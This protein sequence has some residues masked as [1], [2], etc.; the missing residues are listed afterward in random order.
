MTWNWQQNTLWINY[1][2]LWRD[3]HFYLSLDPK[4]TVRFLSEHDAEK[5]QLVD[6]MCWIRAK[7]KQYNGRL[8]A[9]TFSV[10]AIRSDALEHYPNIA[11]DGTKRLSDENVLPLKQLKT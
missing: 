11:P 4:E 7:R 5:P 10:L 2:K 1:D 6:Q 8:L 9:M 3:V